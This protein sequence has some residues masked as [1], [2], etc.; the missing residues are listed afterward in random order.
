MRGKRQIGIQ[1]RKQKSRQKRRRQWQ[2]FLVI[3]AIRSLV[4]NGGHFFKMDVCWCIRC[5]LASSAGK[6]AP[7]NQLITARHVHLSHC[8]GWKGRSVKSPLRESPAK[9]EAW[10]SVVARS[11]G[12][13]FAKTL[14]PSVARMI[15]HSSPVM[16]FQVADFPASL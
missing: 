4:D 12:S 6:R 11:G 15:T 3:L 9:V 7:R 14:S 2:Q 1:E 5:G 13:H 16:R 8:N 10:P